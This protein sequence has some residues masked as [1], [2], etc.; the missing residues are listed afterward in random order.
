[1]TY[2]WVHDQTP[3]DTG[4]PHQSAADGVPPRRLLTQLLM[5]DKTVMADYLQAMEEIEGEQTAT[6]KT[7]IPLR[8]FQTWRSLRQIYPF[9][10]NLIHRF[11]NNL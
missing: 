2:A 7:K 3:L 9:L 10:N 4:L 6:T 11:V 1:M 5:H 8:F